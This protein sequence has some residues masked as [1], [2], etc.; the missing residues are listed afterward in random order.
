MFLLYVL[1]FSLIIAMVLF[2]AFWVVGFEGED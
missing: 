2:I 1:G